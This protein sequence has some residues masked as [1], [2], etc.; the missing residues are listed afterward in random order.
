VLTADFDGDGRLDVLAASQNDDQVRWFE[1]RLT[2]PDCNGNGVP[3]FQDVLAGTSPDCNGNTIPDE[4]DVQ[5]GAAGDCDGDGVLDGCEISAGAADC[6]ADGRPDSC[7]I[8]AD[9]TLDLDGDGVL[10]RCEAV[11][12][13]YCAPATPNSTNR[14][15]VM[16]VLGSAA[17]AQGDLELTARQLPPSTFGYF[18][19]SSTPAALSPIPNSLGTLCVTDSVGR[20]V[21]GSVLNSGPGGAFRGVVDLTALPQPTGPVQVQPGDTWHFQAWHRDSLLGTLTTSNFTDAV[22]VTFL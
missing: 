8:A 16:T 12:L 18:I 19:V 6:D 14:P 5:S 17:I 15:G 2:P 13:S 9:P 11:G 7:D 22:S 3:D 21:G 20:G 10:D 4:C 1:N